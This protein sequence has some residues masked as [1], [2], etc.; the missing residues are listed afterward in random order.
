[1]DGHRH[2]RAAIVLSSYVIGFT[3]AYILFANFNSNDQT[4]N[5]I[6]ATA[7]EDNTASVISAVK[8]NTP[9]ANNQLPI[10]VV[11]PTEVTY[12][13]G[14]LEVATNG[15]IVL[16]SFNPD[17]TDIKV[18]TADL[19]QGFHFGEV[20]YI[21]SPNNQFVFFCEQQD[22][23][24]SA[25]LGFVYDTEAKTIYPVVKNGAPV[26]ISAASLT[27]AKI[28]NSGLSIGTNYS[29]NPSAPWVL[30]DATTTLDLQ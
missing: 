29:P 26:L 15:E 8:P 27:T 16:L 25:C 28:T 2:E 3:A 22:V 6:N 12:T 7:I 11:S 20:S 9:P 10:E 19:S 1:M 24:N 21:L 23:T 18:N 4:L 14:R 13:D 17:I 30:I 5:F